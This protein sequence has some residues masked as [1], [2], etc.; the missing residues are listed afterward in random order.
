[1]V[2]QYTSSSKFLVVGTFQLWVQV[3]NQCI[4]MYSYEVIIK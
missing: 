3:D 4:R 1:M 2:N